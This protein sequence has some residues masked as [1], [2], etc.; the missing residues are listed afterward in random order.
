MSEVCSDTEP[1]VV[2]QA[3]IEHRNPAGNQRDQFRIDYTVVETSTI[4]TIAPVTV[5]SPVG[6][7]NG[8]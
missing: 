8:K 7:D 5:A 1:S 6:G 2:G 4:T 3:F